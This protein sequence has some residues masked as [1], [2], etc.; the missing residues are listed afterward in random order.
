MQKQILELNFVGRYI[1]VGIKKCWAVT[2]LTE[3]ITYKTF[4]QP[5]SAQILFNYLYENF[6][7]TTY[8]SAYEAGFSGY[9]T[10]NYCL[11]G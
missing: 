6:P 7:R 3:H 9:W 10:T 5:P 2:V 8:Y 1:Y 11:W 4:I